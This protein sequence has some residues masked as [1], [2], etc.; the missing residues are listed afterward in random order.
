MSVGCPDAGPVGSWPRLWSRG[1]GRGLVCTA[2]RVLGREA[3]RKPWGSSQ[4]DRGRL[5]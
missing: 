5:V 4:E 3:Q 2:L 1:G